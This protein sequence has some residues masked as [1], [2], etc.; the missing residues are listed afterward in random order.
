MKNVHKLPK[1]IYFHRLSLT[2]DIELFWLLG[3]SKTQFIVGI[4]FPYILNLE[5]KIKRTFNFL[6]FSNYDLL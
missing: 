3:I 5:K 1:S 4:V 6:L 2:F